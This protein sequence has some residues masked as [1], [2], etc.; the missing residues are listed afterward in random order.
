VPKAQIAAFQTALGVVN[1]PLSV[2]HHAAI[3][4]LSQAHMEALNAVYPQLHDQV[5]ASV[6]NRL[7]EHG[8]ARLSYGQ[9]SSLS[10]LMG[11]PMSQHLAP[12]GILAAQ[13]VMQAPQP[14]QQGAVKPSQKGL[15]NLDVSER[16]LTDQQRAASR[17]PS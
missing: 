13:A 8:N 12:Q 2:L 3:G 15:G 14:Q 6:A 1:N 11:A 7:A 5:V 16:L 17:S 10:M 4:T 9:K